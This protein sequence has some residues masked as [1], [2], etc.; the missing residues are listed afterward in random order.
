MQNFTADDLVQTTL[1]TLSLAL[2]LLPP[3]YLLCMASNVFGMRGRSAAE[4]VLFSLAFSFA[5]TP[6]LTVLL[7]RTSS[8][9]VTLAF[10]LVLALISVFSLVRQ[11]PRAAEL[12]SG[13]RRSTWVLCGMV[14]AWFLVV[15]FSLADLQVGHRLY[16]SYTIFDHSLRVSMVE[17][18]VR[19]GVPP[20]NPLFGLGPLPVLRYFYYWYVVCA[21]PVR[22]FGLRARACFNAGVFW[23]GLGLASLIPLF[24]K[25]F[26]GES[27]E[28]RRKSVI[29]IALLSVTGLDLIAYVVWACHSHWLPPDMEWW[30]NN[31]VASWL[32]SLLW[33]PHHVAA[34][35]ACM[36]GLLALSAIDE[37]TPLGQSVWAA[38]LAGLGFASAAGLSVYVVFA[39]AAFMILWTLLMLVQMKIRTCAV[40]LAAGII[41]LP[42]SWPYLQDLTSKQVGAARERF[43]FIAVRSFWPDLD[44][45][46]RLGIHSHWLL[47]LEKLPML[48][49]VYAVEFGFFALIV[50][51]NWR[52]EHLNLIPLSRQRRMAWVMFAVCLLT[53]S[54]VQSNTSGANDLGFRGMLVVQFVLLLWAAPIVDEVFFRPNGASQP[55]LRA[56]WSS[57]PWIKIALTGALALGVAGSALQ[58][59]LLRV[60]APLADTG[61]LHRRESVYGSPGFGERTYWMREGFAR[62][63]EL[64]SPNA[65]V[66]YNP[67]RYEYLIARL[68]STRQVAMGDES[69]GSAFG[70]DPAKC[71]DAFPYFE[72]VF[73][74]PDAVR[75]ANLDQFCSDF[76]VHVLVATDDDSVWD[77][78]YSWVWTRPTLVA[79]PMMRA[80]RCG[81]GARSMADSK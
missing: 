77:D 80:V 5:I 27:E 33:V 36:A 73:N 13:L 49:F 38:V 64:T 21:L 17:A 47:E 32:G 23:S 45:L 60:Y 18:A 46:A 19:G 39:F 51:L 14:L 57:S 50:L 30:D 20:R 75:N 56:L 22:L 48:L 74:N 42:L 69:C 3:G 53:V 12:L 63:D 34:L 31:Q 79:N 4:K 62:L 52:R 10:F 8:Y 66:Q 59:A 67:V 55:E 65:T 15:Q 44:I 72:A 7:T 29:G 71:R 9:K 6:I 58:L 43:A 70:G 26:F 81:T 61:K 40:Y 28:I 1:A 41:S 24:L 37:E 11:L 2:V 76:G 25:Y 16:L 78:P 68:Y 54:V 35:T